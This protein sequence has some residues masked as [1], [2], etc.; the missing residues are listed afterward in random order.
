M[1]VEGAKVTVVGAWLLLRNHR[2]H[3]YA[4]KIVREAPSWDQKVYSALHTLGCLMS[5]NYS[6]DLIYL[7][8]VVVTIDVGVFVTVKVYAFTD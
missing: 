7:V 8:A 6:I 2:Q 5:C 4:L 3:M 1:T